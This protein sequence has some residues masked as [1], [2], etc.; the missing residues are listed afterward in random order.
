MNTRK[1][2]QLMTGQEIQDMLGYDFIDGLRSFFG[3]GGKKFQLVAV[4]T[5]K[6]FRR[7]RLSVEEIKTGKI[8]TIE[9]N[10]KEEKRG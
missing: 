9:L 4:S 10:Y 2:Y 1:G 5:A 8:K 3:V 6:N 7:F